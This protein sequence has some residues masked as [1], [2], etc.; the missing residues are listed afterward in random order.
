MKR[1]MKPSTSFSE[2]MNIIDKCLAR[3]F[4]NNIKYYFILTSYLSYHLKITNMEK[5][6]R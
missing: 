6:T 5:E 1:S 2:K 4:M 3:L